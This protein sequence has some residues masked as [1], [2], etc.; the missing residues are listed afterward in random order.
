MIQA[1]HYLHASVSTTE[2]TSSCRTHMLNLLAK[3]FGLD[4]SRRKTRPKIAL[5]EKKKKSI[6]QDV[7][8]E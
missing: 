1:L 6:M 2:T 5:A 3:S 7:K 8:T 4:F